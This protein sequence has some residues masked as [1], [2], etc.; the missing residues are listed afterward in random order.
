MRPHTKIYFNHFGYK[1]PEDVQ[2]EVCGAPAQDIHHIKARG[3][4]GDPTGK[5]DV[6]E[7]LQAL[8]RP[9]H[10]RYGDKEQYMEMLRAVH[11][12]KLDYFNRRRK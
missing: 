10:E 1:I 5:R 9:C 12:A 4:G 8:C 7:N 6:I 2:C 11:Q 3:M